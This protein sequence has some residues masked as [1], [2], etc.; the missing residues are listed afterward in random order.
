MEERVPEGSREGHDEGG[1]GAPFWP[2]LAHLRSAA[3]KGD[4]ISLP[5]VLNGYAVST[6]G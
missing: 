6:T 2:F 1:H 5:V 3:E 4:R